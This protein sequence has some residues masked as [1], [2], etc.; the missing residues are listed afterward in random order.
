MNFNFPEKIGALNPR[1]QLYFYELFAHFLTFSMRGVLF[2]ET[3]DDSERIER[4][5]WLNEIAHQIT[6]KIFVADKKANSKWTDAEIQRLIQMNI[7]KHP[8][9]EADVNAAIEMSYGYVME[10]ESDSI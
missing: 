7:D 10:N 3:I 5:K 8:A 4:A 6:Y 2:T 1:Q 9:T